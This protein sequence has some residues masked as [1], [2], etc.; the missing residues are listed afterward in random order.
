MERNTIRHFICKRCNKKTHDFLAVLKGVLPDGTKFEDENID[1]C[2][3]CFKKTRKEQAQTALVQQAFQLGLIK[4]E[5]FTKIQDDMQFK[6]H[7][8][9]KLME[10]KREAIKIKN[11][12]LKWK[13]RKHKSPSHLRRIVQREQKRLAEIDGVTH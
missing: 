2:K 3:R 6:K 9:E 1:L 13:T 7:L 4:D 10:L 11:D 5:D 8:F 12:K